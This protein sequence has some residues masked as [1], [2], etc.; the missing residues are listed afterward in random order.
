[1][2]GHTALEG[3]NVN[4]YLGNTVGKLRFG[5]QGCHS[6]LFGMWLSFWFYVLSSFTIAVKKWDILFF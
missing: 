3:R 2:E 1:M 5:L 6:V 4:F